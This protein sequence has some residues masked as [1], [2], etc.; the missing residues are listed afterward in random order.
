MWG[1]LQGKVMCVDV[2]GVVE[3][4]GTVWFD[5]ASSTSGVVQGVA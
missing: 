2:E 4:E 5:M 3:G 1:T